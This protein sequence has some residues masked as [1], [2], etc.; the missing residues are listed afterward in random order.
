[1]IEN[2]SFIFARVWCDTKAITTFPCVKPNPSPHCGKATWLP[3]FSSFS[4][5]TRNSFS[6]ILPSLFSLL[7]IS[8]AESF[9]LSILFLLRRFSFRNVK[10]DTGDDFRKLATKN[11]DIEMPRRRIANEATNNG[12]GDF[13]RSHQVSAGKGGVI[14]R[15]PYN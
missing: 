3:V 8:F 11:S 10:W 5:S 6:W 12:E 14:Y 2:S 1:M 15:T 9:L 13:V 4:A 7:H